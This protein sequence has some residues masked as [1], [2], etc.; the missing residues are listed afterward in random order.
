VST[1]VTTEQLGTAGRAAAGRR[2]FPR[3]SGENRELSILVPT[4]Y[5]E[6]D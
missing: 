3:A 2:D 4:G 6:R 5:R 1:V